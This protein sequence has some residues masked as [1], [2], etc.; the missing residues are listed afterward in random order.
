MEG[1]PEPVVLVPYD[2]AW[3]AAFREI[4]LR[5]RG[6]LGQVARRIDH[7]GS[8]SVPGLGA[9]PIIDLQI[10]VGALEPEGPFRTPLESLGYVFRP[11]DDMRTRRF[12]RHADGARRTHLHVYAQGSFDEQLNLLFRDYL[13]SHAEAAQEYLQEKRR[14]SERFHHDRGAYTEAKAPTIWRLVQEASVWSHR[15]GWAPGPS[16]A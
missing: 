15:T 14:L 6:A 8:T 13:R 7:I 1:Q 2:P 5:V 4:A 12:F 16:D 9:K 10:S 3:P 11:H